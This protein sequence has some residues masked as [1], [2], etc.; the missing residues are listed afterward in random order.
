MNMENKALAAIQAEGPKQKT[1]A[2]Y[3]EW[4][5]KILNAAN[6]VELKAELGED[7]EAETIGSWNPIT[8]KWTGDKHHKLPDL[9]VVME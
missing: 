7:D 3:S 8:Q 1:E 6:G 4:Y 2:G 9:N 5:E